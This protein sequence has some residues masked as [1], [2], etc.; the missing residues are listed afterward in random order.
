M[1]QRFVN[2][3]IGDKIRSNTD[4]ESGETRKE[5]VRGDKIGVIST[6]S[7]VSKQKKDVVKLLKQKDGKTTKAEERSVGR[8][9]T[10]V[11]VSYLKA[12]GPCFIIPILL[13]ANTILDK[14]LQV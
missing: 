3:F 9:K 14:G 5:G 11:Y 4:S 2:L 12:W 13:L 1:N 10:S 7:S 8:V 6:A